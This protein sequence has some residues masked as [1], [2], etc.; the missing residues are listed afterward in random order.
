MPK[1]TLCDGGGSSA[2]GRVL[3]ERTHFDKLANELENVWWGHKTVA[4]QSR[5]DQRRLLVEKL[6]QIGP[7]TLVLEPG[8]GSDEFSSRLAMTGA[9]IVAVELSPKQ[10]RIGRTRL[11]DMKNLSFAVGDVTRLPH[12]DNTFD[13]VIGC[14]VLH[15]LHMPT[16][17]QEFRRVLKPGGRFLFSEPNMLNPQIAIEKNVPSIGRRFGNSP[18]ETAFFRWSIAG[19]L[20]RY[21]FTEVRVFPFDFLHPATPEKWIGLVLHMSQVLERFPIIR[22]FAGSLLIYALSR[23]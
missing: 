11:G 22:E 21:G 13:A 8:A 23:K 12:P 17:L 15:H 18:D 6:A 19:M 9:R 20:R 1:S 3:R 5:L 4:G 2:T 16:A 10:A 14:S 7:G